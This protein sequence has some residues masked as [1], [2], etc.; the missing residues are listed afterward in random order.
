MTRDAFDMFQ[1]PDRGRFGDN[2]QRAPQQRVNGSSDLVDVT[3]ALHHETGRAILAS[4]TG[5]ESSAQWIPKSLI[6]IE[7]KNS[8]LTGHRKNGS[9]VNLQCVVVTI[10]E[11]WAKGKGLL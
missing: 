4:I 3:L 10:P 2:E 9:A 7:R 8:Y 5:E 1:Q 6:E 11:G